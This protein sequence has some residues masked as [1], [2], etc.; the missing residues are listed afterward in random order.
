ML[1]IQASPELQTKT[2]CYLEDYNTPQKDPDKNETPDPIVESCP[3]NMPLAMEKYY[4]NQQNVGLQ[5]LLFPDPQRGSQDV[6]TKLASQLSALIERLENENLELKK[7]IQEIHEDKRHLENLVTNAIKEVT[8]SLEGRFEEIYKKMSEDLKNLIREKN[9]S[10]LTLE[11]LLA[12]LKALQKEEDTIYENW[13][14]LSET[15]LSDFSKMEN[16]DEWEVVDPKN[17]YYSLTHLEIDKDPKKKSEIEKLIIELETVTKLA[18]AHKQIQFVLPADRSSLLEALNVILK[19]I[20]VTGSGTKLT[21][22]TIAFLYKESVRIATL[23]GVACVVIQSPWTPLTN[24][25]A[26]FAFSVLK[27]VLLK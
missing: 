11:D 3:S 27:K 16:R 14:E 15:P 1:K 19:V 2:L 21:F 12:K 24:M 9:V 5:F 20:S 4:Q 26:S 18:E 22:W 7:N 13:H 23:F 8:Y 6:L 25:I 10:H 17:S